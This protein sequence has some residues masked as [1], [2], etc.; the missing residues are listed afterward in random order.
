MERALSV[1]EQQWLVQESLILLCANLGPSLSEVSLRTALAATQPKQPYLNVAI[2]AKA[3]KFKVIE[4]VPVTCEELKDNDTVRAAARRQLD[5]GLDRE[6]SLARAHIITASNSSHLVLVCDH[7]CLDGKSLMIWLTD[8][9]TASTAETECKQVSLLQ[10]EGLVDWTTR[11]PPTS[12]LPFVPPCE[13][14]VLRA[15]SPEPSELLTAKV[16]DIVVSL[17]PTVFSRLLRGTKARGS[18]LNAPLMTAFFAAIADTAYMQNPDIGAPFRVRSC[19]AVDVRALLQPPLPSDF[20][21]NSASVVPAFAVFD[22]LACSCSDD[23]KDSTITN[24]CS[25]DLWSVALACQE[26]MK[27]GLTAGEA[28]RF[29]FVSVCCSFIFSDWSLTIKSI[30]MTG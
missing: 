8:V 11:I 10:G 15:L 12:F 13:S 16:S 2:D 19:C 7:L 29:L 18:T 9:L 5:L 21:N 24:S 1:T 3:L 28:F 23:P 30:T 17:N 27:S 6:V 14:V 4:A 22:S 25:L 26:S 20:M